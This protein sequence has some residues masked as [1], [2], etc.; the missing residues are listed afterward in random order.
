M[1]IDQNMLMLYYLIEKHKE[2]KDM[3]NNQMIEFLLFIFIKK[4]IM[5]VKIKKIKIKY[6]KEIE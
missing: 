5:I 6:Y 4:K 2:I 1:L 3:F